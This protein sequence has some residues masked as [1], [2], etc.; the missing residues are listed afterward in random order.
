M[1]AFNVEGVVNCD[2]FAAARIAVF[3]R[4][5]DSLREF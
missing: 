5:D 4:I 2:D 3:K 1:D